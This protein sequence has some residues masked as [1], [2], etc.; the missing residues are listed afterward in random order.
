MKTI[1]F[2]LMKQSEHRPEGAAIIQTRDPTDP[3]PP[4][5][6]EAKH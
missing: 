2:E 1:T 4:A 3:D 5:Q 6:S